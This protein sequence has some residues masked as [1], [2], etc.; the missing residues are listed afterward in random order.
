MGGVA[1]DAAGRSSVPGLWAC[2][3]TACTG[4]HGAN[5]LAS[6]SLIEAVVC[7]GWVAESVAG[8]AREAVRRRHLPHVSLP[9]ASDPAAVGNILYRGVGVLR[10]E[11]GLRSTIRALL[12]LACSEGPAS[13]PA[14]IGLTIAV[15]AWQR[16]ESRGAHWRTDF[17]S[18]GMARRSTLRLTNVLA[19]ARALNAG[20]APIAR[21]A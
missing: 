2:G 6:N 18:R 3:E 5:R 21:S 16:Q 11:A 8:A 10:D 13:D 4:L 9:P 7:A 14:L 17:P 19:T 12:P 20:R 1:V 15:A